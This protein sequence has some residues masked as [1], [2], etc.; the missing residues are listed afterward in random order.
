[1]SLSDILAIVST[2]FGVITIV[3]AIGQFTET[4]RS[5]RQTSIHA[6]SILVI[7]LEANIINLDDLENG[8]QLPLNSGTSAIYHE[9]TIRLE[10]WPRSGEEARKKR[11][12]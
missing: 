9:G 6:A 2:I 5:H 4:R 10:I 11:A 12:E 3:V 7:P 1:V 8:R